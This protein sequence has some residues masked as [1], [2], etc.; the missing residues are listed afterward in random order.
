MYTVGIAQDQFHQGLRLTR[1]DSYLVAPAWSVPIQ[2]VIQ[3]CF[4]YTPN[5]LFLQSYCK[6]C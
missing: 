5:Q 4:I 1:V 3:A 6:D 2:V